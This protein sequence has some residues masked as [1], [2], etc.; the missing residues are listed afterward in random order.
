MLTVLKAGPQTALQDGGRWG[1]QRYGIGVA[2]ALDDFAPQAANI[3][4]GNARNAA[5]MEFVGHGPTLRAEAP[6]CVAISGGQF[7]LRAG[8]L[9]LPTWRRI[10]LAAGATL[11][12]G[13]AAR[14][15]RGYVAVAGGFDAPVV[16]NSRSTLLLAQIGGYQGRALRAGDKLRTG[17]GERE[18]M[19]SVAAS[20]RGVDAAW[21]GWSINP[22]SLGYS[23]DPSVPF[24]VLEGRHFSRFSAAARAAFFGGTFRIGAQANRMGY[25]LEGAYLEP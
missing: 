10:H 11:S 12:I 19:H 6:L 4:V 9:R 5:V 20:M 3:L 14:G 22:S 24:R 15:Y 18:D 21:S 8:E 1:Y 16:L 17:T 13:R 25:R 2:G 23:V 7:E